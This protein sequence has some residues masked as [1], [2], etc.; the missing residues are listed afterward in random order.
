MGKFSKSF[1]VL[2]SEDGGQV[3]A[4]LDDARKF[5]D[6]GLFSGALEIRVVGEAEGLERVRE[7]SVAKAPRKARAKPEAAAA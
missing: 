3:Q 2:V 5:I 1:V 7:R 4:A 6:S